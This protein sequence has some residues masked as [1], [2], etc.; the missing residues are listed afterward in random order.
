[1]NQNQSH[2]QEQQHWQDPGHNRWTTHKS[3][4]K[5]CLVAEPTCSTHFREQR[6][7][8]CVHSRK[9]I[10]SHAYFRLISKKIKPTLNR[11]HRHLPQH[12]TA[13]PTRC[14]NHTN[15][16]Y[17]TERGKE[18]HLPNSAVN[19]KLLLHVNPTFR[20]LISVSWVDCFSPAKCIIRNLII[21]F[22]QL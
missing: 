2:D 21:T 18:F 10:S 6:K 22:P 11:T 16:I 4:T 12:N 17:G 19:H 1:M 9:K 8:E 13:F 3:T 15:I 7:K 20:V 5:F 14:T